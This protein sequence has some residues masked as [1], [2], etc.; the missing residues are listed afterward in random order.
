MASLCE[1]WGLKYA[2]RRGAPP[3]PQVQQHGMSNLRNA[4]RD[5]L[6]IEREQPEEE[7]DLDA[8]LLDLRA[9]LMRAQRSSEQRAAAIQAGLSGG[10]QEANQSPSAPLPLPRTCPTAMAEAS[11]ETVE[12]EAAAIRARVL[13]HKPKLPPR[14]AAAAPPPPPPPAP[15]HSRAAVAE[16]GEALARPLNWREKMAVD[17]EQP[18][19]AMLQGGA[20][21]APQAAS[22]EGHGRLQG[23]GAAGAPEATAAQA[24]LQPPPPPPPLLPQPHLASPALRELH[25]S[26]TP[27]ERA[28]TAAL[29]R[30]YAAAE[31]GEGSAA[32][33][34]GSGGRR[35][36]LKK[37]EVPVS[38]D[39]GEDSTSALLLPASLPTHSL[40]PLRAQ[41]SSLLPRARAPLPLPQPTLTLEGSASGPLKRG[42]SRTL[43]AAALEVVGSAPRAHASHGKVKSP[44]KN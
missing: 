22:D 11:N 29:L 38:F 15:F 14:L 41:G 16:V 1:S 10:A 42:R 20:A 25:N 12:R 9:L 40:P 18:L 44:H 43:P 2:P 13:G 36:S 21:P 7:E 27:R 8:G 28:L 37:R 26:I 39:L 34:G 4:L 31:E 3:W 30:K 24:A 6:Q 17:L 32:S 23:E 35:P 19:R 5:L 33:G